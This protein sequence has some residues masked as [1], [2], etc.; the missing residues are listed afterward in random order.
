[1]LLM[2]LACLAGLADDVLA[3]VPDALALVR[4]GLAE[5]PDLGGDLAD[6]LLVDAADEDLGGGGDLEGHALGR[7]VVDGVAVAERQL[8]R[9]RAGVQDAVADADDLELLGE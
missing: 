3:L 9:A 6:L 7:L 1:M 5:V 2:S 8:E 4:L